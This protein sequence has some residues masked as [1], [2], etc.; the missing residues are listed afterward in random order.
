MKTILQDQFSEPANLDEVADQSIVVH[1]RSGGSAARIV[2]FVHGLGG[3]RYG[4][5]STWGN[6]PKFIFE[7]VADLDVGIYQYETLWRRLKFG[8]QIPLDREADIFAGILRDELA[9]YRDIIL[10]GHSMGGVLCKALIARLIHDRRMDLLDRVAGLFLLASPQLGSLRVPRSLSWFSPDADALKPHGPLLVDIARTFEDYLLLDIEA[11][12]YDKP[13]IPTFAVLGAS[14]FWV[15]ELSAGIGL[16]TRQKKT[17][18]GTHIDVVK[19]RSKDSPVYGWVRDKVNNCLA[20]FD[21]DVFLAMAMAGLDT[22]EQYQSYRSQALKIEKWLQDYCGFRSV[23]YAGRHIET[24][25][26]FEAEDFSLSQDLGALR[27]SKYFM[28]VY[29]DKI[30]SSVLFEAGLAVALGKPSVYF[31]RDRSSLPFL[32]KQAEQAVLPAGVRI[33]Q[34]ESF[35]KIEALLQKNGEALWKYLA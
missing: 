32:M 16:P 31:I 5:E 13:V 26:Q 1:R 21:H 4:V 33:Y 25:D 9:G 34:Y 2:I 20:R 6:F 28:L 15:D 19:P 14:D 18:V 11:L 3:S 30:V 10:V 27:R 35:A 12:S 24:K 23:F 17:V 22:E 8:A 7:D 29:P